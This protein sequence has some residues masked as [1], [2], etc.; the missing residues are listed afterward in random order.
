M[1][2]SDSQS[3]NTKDAVKGDYVLKPSK[4]VPTLNTEEWPL[5]L[6]VTIYQN[7]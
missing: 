7:L 2:D 1:S 4:K 6:K 5:L 3:D